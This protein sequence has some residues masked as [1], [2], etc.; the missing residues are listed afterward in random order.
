MKALPS[1]IKFFN[2]RSVWT[3]KS[4]GVIMI[5]SLLIITGAFVIS[6]S[7]AS[8]VMVA[9][10]IS[11]TQGDSVRAY[12]AADS[13]LERAL[14]F[15]QQPE[16]SID[17]RNCP[18]GD[19]CCDTVGECLFFDKKPLGHEDIVSGCHPCEDIDNEP[20]YMDPLGLDKAKSYQLIYQGVNFSRSELYLESTGNSNG[21][22]RS[23]KLTIYRT[24]GCVP[25]CTYG[26][27]PLPKGCGSNGCGGSCGPA[28]PEGQ[29]C[30]SEIFQCE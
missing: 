22:K 27:P 21:V 20:Q 6:L 24:A 15:D 18:G 2:W 8:L 5:V 13:G 12:F 16:G 17:Q 23:I 29:V 26:D 14:A 10:S 19:L 11:R 3:A 9:I 30:S 1:A 25:S 28:C 4:S 7:I